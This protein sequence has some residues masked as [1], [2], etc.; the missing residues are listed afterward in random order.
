MRYILVDLSRAAAQVGLKLHMGKTKI[1]SN[2]ALRKG[3]LAQP[4]IQIGMDWVE[5]LPYNGSVTYL[6]RFVSFCDF[7]D[8][9]MK[10]R[11]NRGWAVF[12]NFRAVLCCRHYPLRSRLRLFESVITPVVLCGSACW[13]MT[14]LLESYISTVRRTMLRKIVGAARLTHVDGEKEPWHCWIIRVTEKG[15]KHAADVG[16]ISWIEQQ[17][18]RRKSLAMRISKGPG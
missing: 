5:V 10:H 6:G 15:E 7:H 14:A 13:T 9:E 16:L 3:V 8:V 12:A 17:K 18:L 4:R 1:L 11:I 2:V